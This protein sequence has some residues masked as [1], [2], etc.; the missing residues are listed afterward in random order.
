MIDPK[1]SSDDLR[2]T[3]LFASGPLPYMAYNTYSSILKAEQITRAGQET[4]LINNSLLEFA[5]DV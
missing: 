5:L 4:E 3:G 1:D 2:R